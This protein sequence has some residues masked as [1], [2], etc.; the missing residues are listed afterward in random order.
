MDSQHQ[1]R[2]PPFALLLLFGLHLFP[3]FLC[4]FFFTV[5]LIISSMLTYF[6]VLRVHETSLRNP[7]K[8]AVSAGIWRGC[9]LPKAAEGRGVGFLLPQPSGGTSPRAHQ[10]S[11]SSFSWGMFKMELPQPS[12]LGCTSFHYLNLPSPLQARLP[13]QITSW[14]SCSS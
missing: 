12:Q 6:S 10:R 8:Q 3:F 11:F 4:N 13:P 1:F 7:Q 2:D 9:G 5:I 14:G